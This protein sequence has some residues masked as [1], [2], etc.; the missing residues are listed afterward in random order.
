MK[1]LVCYKEK[2]VYPERAIIKLEHTDIH[3]NSWYNPVFHLPIPVFSGKV[4][5]RHTDRQTDGRTE[6]QTDSETNEQTYRHSSSLI[7]QLLYNFG[8]TLR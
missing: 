2:K 5:S 6:T 1:Q 8:P 4:T 7:A 3:P